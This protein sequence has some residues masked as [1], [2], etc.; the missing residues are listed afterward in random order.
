MIISTMN[1]SLL[2]LQHLKVI[3]DKLA[4][5]PKE[6]SQIF[7]EVDAQSKQVTVPHTGALGQWA[8]G[9]E[10]GVLQSDQIIEGF[11]ATFNLAMYNNSYDI[12]YEAIRWDQYGVMNTNPNNMVNGLNYKI[13]S[14]AAAVLNEGFATT[15]G[16]DGVY[17]FSNSHPLAQSASYGDNLFTGALGYAKVQEAELLMNQGTVSESN[18]PTP[19]RP[20]TLWCAVGLH[21]TALEI[22]T[23]TNIAG[24][25]SNTKGSLPVLKVAPMSYVT[26]G[27]W[28]L[29]DSQFADN[30]L[31]FMWFDK[32]MF[33]TEPIPGRWNVTKVMGY[34]AFQAGYFDWRGIVGSTG[35]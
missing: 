30:N 6:Y 8:E 28:G 12:T 31:I 11:T 27:Y 18:M 15:T 26:A 34:T 17:L 19:S 16:F 32:P 20:D 29:K 4:A 14:E 1:S 24:E 5:A 9:V 22:L 2:E 35:A 23:S 25:L 7:R 33:K 3:S 10:G 13:E 21:R